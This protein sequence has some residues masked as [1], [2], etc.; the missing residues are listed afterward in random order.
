MQKRANKRREATQLQENTIR[1]KL[2]G[3]N[4]TPGKRRH[5]KPNRNFIKQHNIRKA[6]SGK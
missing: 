1:H 3:T 6:K 2:P 5:N 4:K